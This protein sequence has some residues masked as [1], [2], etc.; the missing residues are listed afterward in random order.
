MEFLF[1]E[2]QDMLRQVELVSDLAN[3]PE[4]GL[5]L[6]LGAAAA[7][8]RRFRAD[9]IRHTARIAPLPAYSAGLLCCACIPALIFSFRTCMP[10]KTSPLPGPKMGE[11][12]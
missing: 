12:P 7:F 2:A 1:P 4:R 6:A 10:L 3:G 5:G 9:C 11:T 8:C